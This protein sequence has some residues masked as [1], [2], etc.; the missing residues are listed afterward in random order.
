[1]SQGNEAN[2]VRGRSFP[3]RAWAVRGDG[4][5]EI[6]GQSGEQCSNVG[7]SPADLGESDQQEDPR[8]PRLGR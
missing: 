5:V 3:E 6:A 8:A 7:L 1:V 4:D 2:A